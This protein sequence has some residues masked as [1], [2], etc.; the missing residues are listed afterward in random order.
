M[1][2]WCFSYQI[3]SCTGNRLLLRCLWGHKTLCALPSP[4]PPRGSLSRTQQILSRAV[5]EPACFSAGMVAS[6][7][8]Q[9]LLFYEVSVIPWDWWELAL[10]HSDF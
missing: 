5:P 1:G 9:D 7:S 8:C 3:I 10:H 2:R 6:E 4:N